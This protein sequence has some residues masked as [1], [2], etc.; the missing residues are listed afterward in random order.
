MNATKIPT[1]QNGRR[2]KPHDGATEWSVCGRC[3]EQID[4]ASA[5]FGPDNFPTKEAYEESRDDTTCPYCG[6]HDTAYLFA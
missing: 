3:G 6:H 1:P 4:W 5:M 2:L